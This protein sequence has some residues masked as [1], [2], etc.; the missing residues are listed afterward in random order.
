MRNTIFHE[1]QYW[2]SSLTYASTTV[3]LA[4]CLTNFV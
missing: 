3:S 1:Q 2:Q 4:A